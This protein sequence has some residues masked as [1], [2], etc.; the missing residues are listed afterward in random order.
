MEDAQK[1]TTAWLVISNQEYV[2]LDSTIQILV[3]ANV[4]YAQKVNIAM[5][6]FLL[7]QLDYVRKVIFV[8]KEKLHQSL[9]RVRKLICIILSEVSQESVALMAIS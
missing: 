5:A 6:F 9:K 2:R 4:K 3:K 7:T 8:M 1:A